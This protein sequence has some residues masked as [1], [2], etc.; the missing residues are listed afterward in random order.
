MSPQTLLQVLGFLLRLTEA[1]LK[2]RP[3]PDQPPSR[4]D[5]VVARVAP[6]AEKM[7]ERVAPPASSAQPPARRR[8]SAGKAMLRAAAFSAL[9]SGTAAYFILQHQ[10][11][12]RERYTPRHAPFP[13]TLLD[14]LAAPGG[15]G[16]LVFSGA[17]LIDAQTGAIY[18]VVDG[19]PDFLPA[20]G[21]FAPPARMDSLLE[22]VEPVRRAVTGRSAP[23]HAAWAGA[24]AASAPA[25]G[26]LLCAVADGA[27]ALE[28]AQVN[29]TAR[30]LCLSP[31]WNTVLEVR[32][33]ARLAS[34]SNLYFARGE[35]TLL[36][37]RDAALTAMW[38]EPG[39]SAPERWLTQAVRALQTGARLSGLAFAASSLDSALLSASGLRTAHYHRAFNW[40]R[41]TG[42]KA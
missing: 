10:R 34:L 11:R 42:L 6:L 4:A 25:G 1:W 13:E 12:V 32:R 30:V 29:P 31:E 39:S 40:V 21:A 28:M 37:V 33:Q 19:I 18:P 36:P 17:S 16:R 35:L 38:L 9:V 22:M 20:S 41:F 5:R 15:G 3:A 8:A 7:L 23:S 2:R 26:W 14:I 24:L 27:H